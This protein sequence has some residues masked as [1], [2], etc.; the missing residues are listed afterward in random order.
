MIV[1]YDNPDNRQKLADVDRS[2]D[3]VLI[4]TG[5]QREERASGMTKVGEPIHGARATPYFYKSA[6]QPTLCLINC[7][8]PSILCHLLQKTLPRVEKKKVAKC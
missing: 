8:P 5:S 1:C 3:S 4:P 2:L 7:F 6:Y